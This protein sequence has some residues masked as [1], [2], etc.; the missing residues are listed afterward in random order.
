MYCT[1][2]LNYMLHK[3]CFGLFQ[4]RV[5]FLFILQKY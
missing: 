3:I 4:K 5:D 1:T 2:F